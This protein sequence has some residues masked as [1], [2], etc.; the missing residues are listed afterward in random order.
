MPIVKDPSMAMHED[1]EVELR[2]IVRELRVEI[3]ELKTTILWI[4]NRERD[5]LPAE[6]RNES[7][8]L[9]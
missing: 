6:A 5:Q 7:D 4:A 8:T 3:R 9:A 1:A 2:R